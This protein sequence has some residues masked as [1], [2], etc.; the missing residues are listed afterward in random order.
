MA[1]IL[2]LFGAFEIVKFQWL[3]RSEKIMSDFFTRENGIIHLIK[4]SKIWQIFL[5]LVGPF[6]I[7]MFRRLKRYKKILSDLFT[8]ENG[9]LDKKNPFKLS[10]FNG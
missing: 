1:N 3:K 2:L 5:A 6:E 4:R 9:T 8:H 7:V 10:C